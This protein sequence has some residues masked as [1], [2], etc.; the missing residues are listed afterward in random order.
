MEMKTER[1]TLSQ[2]IAM[3]HEKPVSDPCCT[4]LH[5]RDQAMRQSR[6]GFSALQSMVGCAGD[7]Q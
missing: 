6:L 3:R 1:K 4:S 5:Y 2:L 7:G